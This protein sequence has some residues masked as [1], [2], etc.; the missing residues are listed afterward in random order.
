MI[1]AIE[2]YKLVIGEVLKVV[3]FLSINHINQRL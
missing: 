3:H 1:E 2:P